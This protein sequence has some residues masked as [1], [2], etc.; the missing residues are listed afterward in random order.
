MAKGPL[1]KW[2]RGAIAL[3]FLF[4]AVGESSSRMEMTAWRT[5]PETR[6]GALRPEAS[7]FRRV[8]WARETLQDTSTATL[9]LRPDHRFQKMEGYG[10]ALTEASVINLLKLKP[11]Q[12]AE[13]LK[14]LFDA[15]SGAGFSLIRVPMGS[16]D[17][18]DGAKGEYTYDDSPGNQ[19][20][21]ELKFFSMARDQKTLD[22]LKEIKAVNPRVKLMINPWSAP[23]W[24]K[25]NKHLYRGNFESKYT[26]AL[27]KYFLRTIDEY[28]KAG[29]D[30]DYVGI[31]NE[32]GIE[33]DYPSM[34]MDDDQQIAV[35][36]ALGKKLVEGGYKARILSNDDNYA[37]MDRVIRM[38]AD[39]KTSKYVAAAAF[40]C[41]SNDPEQLDRLD[42]KVVRFESECGGNINSDNFGYD[43]HWWNTN[44]V[45][46]TAKRN[47]SAII[48]WNMVSD[49]F[50]GPHGAGAQGCKTCRGLVVV[51]PDGK[52]GFK[53]E[54]QSEYF[55]L[56]HAA[57]FVR[58]EALRIGTK[59]VGEVPDHVAFKNP[60]GSYVV[61]VN[62]WN[63]G[64]K[65][66]VIK[67]G[68]SQIAKYEIGANEAATLV[69]K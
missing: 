2:G 7:T 56:A 37:G 9:E 33:I 18:A 57:K 65:S 1:S 17:L 28:R 49:E 50:A 44:R 48:A 23:A 29:L 10:A 14:Q 11:E 38:A 36:R 34:L 27:V 52:G 41:W 46:G 21:P 63:Q 30:V 6:Q 67:L 22:L 61:L 51:R 4:G 12:R 45:I 66:L 68:T 64:K 16:S 31:Q 24:M 58:R 8:R 62:N 15:D 55:A 42:P 47:V 32:P 60:D 13:T 5:S 35:I 25:T 3:S 19:P 26:K 53:T 69:I 54:L 43:F 20:D 40:H 39:P 59:S